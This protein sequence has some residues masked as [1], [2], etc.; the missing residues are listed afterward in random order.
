MIIIRNAT[1][2]AE[3]KGAFDRGKLEGHAAAKNESLNS[4]MVESSKYGEYKTWL[5]QFL[6]AECFIP[7][8]IVHA[9][10]LIE[11]LNQWETL[12]PNI[13]EVKALKAS[14]IEFRQLCEGAEHG[15]CPLPPIPETKELSQ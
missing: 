1:Y 9:K 6:R 14:V 12:P 4:Y 7:A 13:R 10:K 8:F 15:A 3:L 5:R 11:T 2:W